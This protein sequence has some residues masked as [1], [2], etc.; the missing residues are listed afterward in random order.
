VSGIRF[1][2]KKEANRYKE[3]RLLVA[4]GS[5]KDLVLQPRY[6][7]QDSFKDAM[8]KKH[9]KIEYVSD[10]EYFDCELGRTIVEDV[11]GFRTDVY[12]IKKKLF[13]NKHRDYY[14]VES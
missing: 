7:L 12:R 1:D 5:I 10:F 2:S 6:L 14:F 13:L 3:L 9:R 4:A 8:G 11:K